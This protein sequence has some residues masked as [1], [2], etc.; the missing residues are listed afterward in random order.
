MNREL[1]TM[2]A[3]DATH[4]A[5]GAVGGTDDEDAGGDV[6]DGGESTA[7]ADGGADGAGALPAPVALRAPSGA[8]GGIPPGEDQDHH[9]SNNIQK[10]TVDDHLAI[11]DYMNRELLTTKAAPDATHAA[12]GAAG[13]TDDDDG[14]VETD[15]GRIMS[16]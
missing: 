12:G 16:E 7:P 13:G 15:D 10:N 9:L 1:L 6:E 4:A 14:D 3:P 2:A 5:G 8:A 11:G